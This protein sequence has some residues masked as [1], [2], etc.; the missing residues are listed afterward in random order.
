MADHPCS[1]LHYFPAAWRA[2]RFPI[3]WFLLAPF[4]L[5]F[6]FCESLW[7]FALRRI[8]FPYI[9][10]DP[11]SSIDIVSGSIST[12]PFLTLDSVVLFQLRIPLA[13]RS[14]AAL[15][16]QLRMQYGKLDSAESMYV[17]FPVESFASP[18]FSAL[19]R[20]FGSRVVPT[21]PSETAVSDRWF[22]FSFISFSFPSVCRFSLAQSF[23]P[24]ASFW[25]LWGFVIEPIAMFLIDPSDL[26]NH[27]S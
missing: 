15:P 6:G 26:S 4:V 23:S 20:I 27:I 21:V 18:S 9:F 14:V 3:G 24:V 11:R 17:P 7:P 16:C 13:R 1:R 8:S 12:L 25:P 2:C 19:R 22:C 10:F 5:R